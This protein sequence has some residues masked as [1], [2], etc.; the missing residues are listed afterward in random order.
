MLPPARSFFHFHYPSLRKGRQYTFL[1]FL[2]H[3][4][5]KIQNN[6]TPAGNVI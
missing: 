3:S 1:Y 4:L 5:L 2:T 6:C